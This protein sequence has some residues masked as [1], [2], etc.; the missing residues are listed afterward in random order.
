MVLDAGGVQYLYLTVM[1]SGVDHNRA[2]V[3]RQRM[4]GDYPS[5]LPTECSP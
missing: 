3:S 2:T 4:G 1:P 5:Q